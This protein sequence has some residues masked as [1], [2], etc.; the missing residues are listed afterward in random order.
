MK[1]GRSLTAVARDL[2]LTQRSLA[3]W[4]RQAKNNHGQ[5]ASAAPT[6]APLQSTSASLSGVSH[7]SSGSHCGTDAATESGRGIRSLW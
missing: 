2:G 1:S 7:S 3:A 5:G 4:V 6:D